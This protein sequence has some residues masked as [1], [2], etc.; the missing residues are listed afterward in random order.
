MRRMFYKEEIWWQKNGRMEEVKKPL[1]TRET[2][3]RKWLH[4]VGGKGNS[5]PMCKEIYIIN[6]E[7]RWKV[8]KIKEV[9]LCGLL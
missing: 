8:R 7:A 4:K 9:T 1:M 5:R 6:G 3:N 2:S